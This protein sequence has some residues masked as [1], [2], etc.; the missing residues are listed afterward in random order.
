MVARPA[1]SEIVDGSRTTTKEDAMRRN[2]GGTKVPPGFYWNPS[3]WR[4]VTVEG[5]QGV[6]PGGQEEKYV[7]VPAAGMLAL[8]PVLGLAFVIFLPFVGFAMVLTQIGKR[9]MALG[10][11]VAG[12][13][14]AEPAPAPRKHTEGRD[15]RRSA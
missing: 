10:R 4:I 1:G 9:G 2:A 13:L 7:K 12:K 8:A 3:D 14:V 15:W 5:E 6:L 11:R